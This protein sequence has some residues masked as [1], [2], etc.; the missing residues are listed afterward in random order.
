MKRNQEELERKVFFS[1]VGE[2]NA[3]L[4]SVLSVACYA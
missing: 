3:S 4:I 2:P 1:H